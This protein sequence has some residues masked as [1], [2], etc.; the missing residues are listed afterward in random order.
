M[1]YPELTTAIADFLNRDD[2]TAQIPTFIRLAEAR[3]DRD[4]DHWA[5]EK[6]VTLTGGGVR[7]L[8]ADYI[9][10]TRVWC[11]G[12]VV[13]TTQ[14]DLQVKRDSYPGATGKAS[15]WAV[16]GGQAEFFPDTTDDVDMA[17]RAAIPR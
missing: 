10:A 9:A 12:P 6:R 15:F 11:G 2:L 16:V 5:G 17:Y 8:P 3:L 1:N 14:D 4:V 13:L 7:D